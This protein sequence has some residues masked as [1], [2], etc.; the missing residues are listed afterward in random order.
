MPGPIDLRRILSA[1]FAYRALGFITGQGGRARFVEDHLRARAGMRILD[2]GCG[3]GDILD[4]LPEQVEYLGF[5]VS[6]EYI[7][8]ARARYGNRAQ[9]FCQRV[10]AADLGHGGS[11][12]IVIAS[13]VLHHLD[14]S[15]AIDLFRL[16]Y[17]ALLPGGRLVTLDG[18]YTPQQS[19]AARALLRMDRGRHVRT[20]SAYLDL[21][22]VVFKEVVSRVRHDLIRLPY[23]HVI[24]ECTR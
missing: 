3:P 21:A 24:L 23:T 15:E 20:E 17:G 12:D 8:S 16:A 4:Y 6:A 1:P 19:A 14:D 13:G 9:F 5:D 10:S 7:E 11:F 18:C 22:Q 2:I